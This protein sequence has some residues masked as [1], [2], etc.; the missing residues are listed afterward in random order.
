MNGFVKWFNELVDGN[1]RELKK[2]RKRVDAINA[3][4]AKVK[5]AGTSGTPCKFTN[6]VQRQ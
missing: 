5:K 3:L 2:Y 1:E 6:P 4:E